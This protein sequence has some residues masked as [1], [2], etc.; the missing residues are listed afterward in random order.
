M[1]C[2][3]TIEISISDQTLA[4]CHAEGRAVRTYP[5]S[6]ARKGPGQLRDSYCTP[7]GK[8]IIRARIGDGQPINTVF[9][10]RRPTGEIYRFDMRET[11]PERDWILTRILWLSGLEVGYNR[12]GNVDTMRRYIY[13][14]GCPD[15][16]DL[17]Q[18]GS[19][20]CIRMSNVDVIDL[21]DSTFIGTPVVIYA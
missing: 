21:F 6:T 10:A 4:L 11:E 20:G 9:R 8:H 2:E 13:I 17:G 3:S 15:D 19:R 5:V 7:L 16:V 18:P 1:T 14:H 12:L